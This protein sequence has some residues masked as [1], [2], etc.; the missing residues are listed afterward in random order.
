MTPWIQNFLLQ[1]KNR[2]GLPQNV[3][4]VGSLNVNGS[5]R[6]V[7][8]TATYKGIDLTPGN[9]VDLVLNAHDLEDKELYDLVICCEVLEHDD[10]F[11]V[12]IANMRQALK[13]GGW[14]VIT[15]PGF[16][17]PKHEFPKDYYRFLGQIYI[18]FFFK[19]MKNVFVEEFCTINSNTEK[20]DW[21]GGF[22]QK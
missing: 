1:V 9:G 19:G 11:W 16:H 13:V 10:Q 12:T 17:F 3:L 20:P 5:A 8:Q 15:T 22:A 7:F 4:E 18:D 21:V 6:E 2:V 14:L